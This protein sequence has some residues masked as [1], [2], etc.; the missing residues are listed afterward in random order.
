MECKG[1]LLEMTC[2]LE[3]NISGFIGECCCNCDLQLEIKVC[4]CGRCSKVKGYICMMYHVADDNHKCCYSED[5][6]GLCE[7][8]RIK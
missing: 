8:W 6:H 7:E 1:E 5:K 3:K 4:S 2:C